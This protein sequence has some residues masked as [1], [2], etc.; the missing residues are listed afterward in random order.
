[1]ELS[2]ILNTL[3]GGSEKTASVSE[4]I[5]SSS[6]SAAIDRALAPSSQEKTASDA[7]TPGG[8]LMKMASDLATA[9]QEALVKEAHIYGVAVADGFVHR[10]NQLGASSITK[11]ASQSGGASS[12]M[13]KQAMELGYNKTM[14]ALA[15][16]QAPRRQQMSKT[17]HM[18]KLAAAQIKGREDAVKIAAHLKGREDA[19]KLASHLKG[20]QDAEKVASDLLKVA[21]TY[22]E[23]G[24]RTG[25]NIL[26]KLGR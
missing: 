2:E 23:L 8:D 17:A 12:E 13:I 15:G 4:D 5:G 9:E 26:A 14:H 20:R 10:M 22:E 21:S 18:N 19:V 3:S 24:F 11:T 7:G 6:L 16:A 1:M 25:T